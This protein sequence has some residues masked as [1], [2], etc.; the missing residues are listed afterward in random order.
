MDPA[1]GGGGDAPLGARGAGAYNYLEDE[2]ILNCLT[3]VFFGFKVHA[4][5]DEMILLLRSLRS[6][7]VPMVVSEN[8]RFPGQPEDMEFPPVQ[9][10]PKRTRKRSRNNS[11]NNVTLKH[12]T[13]FTD[14]MKKSL[15]TASLDDDDS[16]TFIGSDTHI[17]RVVPLKL[18]GEGSYGRVYELEL[19]G[20]KYIIKE[21]KWYAQHSRDERTPADVEEHCRQAFR[22][23]FINVVLQH[24]TRYGAHVGRLI[25]VLRDGENILFMIEHIDNTLEQYINKGNEPLQ[26]AIDLAKERAKKAKEE[27]KEKL[28]PLNT[29]ETNDI[30]IKMLRDMAEDKNDIDYFNFRDIDGSHSYTITHNPKETNYPYT[31]KVFYKQQVF[32]RLRLLEGRVEFRE[33]KIREKG[34]DPRNNPTVVNLNNDKR[35]VLQKFILALKSKEDPA[36]QSNPVLQSNTIDI[37]QPFLYPVFHTLGAVLR[38][39]RDTYGFYHRDLHKGNIMVTDE[40]NVKLIDFGMSCMKGMM[41]NEERERYDFLILVCNILEYNPGYYGVVENNLLSL[42]DYGGKNIYYIFKRLTSSIFHQ[43]YYYKMDNPF[44]EWNKRIVDGKPVAEWFKLIKDKFRPENFT[45]LWGEGE[46]EVYVYD[47]PCDMAVIMKAMN[48]NNASKPG[49]R[50]NTKNKRHNAKAK[51]DGGRRTRRKARR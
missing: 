3:E 34:K 28:V 14:F 38:H 47:R 32:A 12:I 50:A 35:R 29:V 39:F 43:V 16:I 6:G 10:L 20:R 40:G 1:G 18:I 15:L 44:S 5:R 8:V 24:D 21:D 41:Q 51:L 2:T 9:V 17:E 36:L 19:E 4:R 37:D 48:T 22:E 23:A 45:L 26:G 33:E 46:P 49:I 27:A 30:L 25:K 7:P 11:S 42:F 13:P 31:F